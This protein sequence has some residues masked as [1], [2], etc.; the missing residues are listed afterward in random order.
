MSVSEY[1]SMEAEVRGGD[2]PRLQIDIRLHSAGGGAFGPGPGEI[3]R[4]VRE[5]FREALR[6]VQLERLTLA[7]NARPKARGWLRRALGFL[8]CV[9]IGAVA[10]LAVTS[11]RPRASAVAGLE[12]LGRPAATPGSQS[13]V[14]RLPQATPGLPAS[15][16]GRPRARRVPRH[17]ACTNNEGRRGRGRAPAASGGP[18]MSQR[19]IVGPQQRFERSGAQRLR[20]IRPITTRL[21]SAMMSE[22]SGVMLASGA[23][24][25]FV[26]PA[27]V[28][29]V[30][31][32]SV[33]Y[34][35]LVLTR[36]VTL[37][38]RLPRTARMRDWNH[39]S[40]K[41]RRPRM[42]EGS[43]HLGRDVDG[44]ELWIAFE[45]GRQHATVPGTTG[46]G[47]TTALLSFLA[48]ALTH[49]SGFVIVDGKADNKLY[50]EVLALA[51][52]FGR[53]D[54]VLCLNFMVASGVKDSN[55]FNPFAVGNADAI[56]EML[57]SL[58]GEPAPGDA[59]GV[60]RERAVAL[61]GTLTP[62]LV[63]MRDHKNVPLNIETIRLSFEFRSIW[64]VATKRVF[65]VR[66]P[67]TGETTDIPV[68]EMPEDLIY[69]L[70]AYLG[71]LP[72]YDMSLDW[73][74]QKTEEPSKQHGFAQFY[75]THTF[76]LLGVSLGHIFKVRQSD[77]DM[78][79]VVL[80]RRILVVNLPALESS[81]ER[82]AALGKIVVASLRGMM[83][84][85]LGARLEGDSDVI[86]ANKPG[87][88]VAPFH[89]VLDE[90]GYYAT[91]GMD[92]MLAQGRGLN[93][94]FWLGFQEVSGI[95]ARLGEKT[96]SLLGN[97]NLTVAMRQQDANRTRAM[98]RGY[99]RQDLC[100]PGDELRGRRDRANMPKAA[101]PRSARSPASTGATCRA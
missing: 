54:D 100:H 53:E 29:F 91:S 57:S 78:R 43:I 48:N 95:W 49:A 88:G 34:A 68:P 42:A 52:R 16:Q 2:P 75:F 14:V 58:L 7:A 71:E 70:Q 6:D 73:N 82:L 50:G 72:S 83:A 96:Q 94:M 33:L 38:L 4:A 23:M 3:E 15:P 25:M 22:F 28:N 77:V 47:K 27:L 9:G 87:M 26:E 30:T 97:G 37:P 69:P 74:R 10:S 93:L 36:R 90:V 62:V 66:N 101:R 20:D 40:P 39:P 86:V 12:D 99:R 21:W 32:A 84:Q 76:Q 5:G 8:V 17:S 1:A 46:A 98:D 35:G 65:E 63:W 80:N 60:F 64:K 61:V 31:P 11:Y 89:V 85:M 79:D 92:R 67:M 81:D 55:R 24:L 56:G 41:G 19:E 45:D 51:R 44:R 13:S 18:I 59:N